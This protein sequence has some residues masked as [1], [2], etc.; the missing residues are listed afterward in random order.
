MTRTT[1]FYSCAVGVL[2]WLFVLRAAI[3]LWP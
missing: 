1:L 3:L 2:L